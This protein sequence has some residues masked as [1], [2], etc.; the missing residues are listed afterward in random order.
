LSIPRSTLLI[1]CLATLIL[2]GDVQTQE[3][4][5]VTGLAGATFGLTRL[6]GSVEALV[7]G[8]V[9]LAFRD[10][11]A[12]GGFGLGMPGVVELEGAGLRQELR[13]GYGGLML[14]FRPPDEGKI[15]VG[16]RLLLGAGNAQVRAQPIGNQLGSDNFIVLEPQAIAE[17][18]RHSLVRL[19][20][21]GGYRLVYGVQDLPGIERNDLRDWTVSLSVAIGGAR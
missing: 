8:W 2:P 13:F 19:T 9:G 21:T 15:L 10:R 17:L 20:I 12:I 3:S 11:F 1:T 4:G 16:G 18:P 14:D 7:G 6:A 5:E